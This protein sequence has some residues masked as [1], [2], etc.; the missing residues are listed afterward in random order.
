[1]VYVSNNRGTYSDLVQHKIPTLKATLFS[2][3]TFEAHV[4]A[5][6]AHVSRKALEAL[7]FSQT[8]DQDLRAML[9]ARFGIAFPPDTEQIDKEANVVYLKRRDDSTTEI[10]EA[11][12]KTIAPKGVQAA[13]TKVL[14]DCKWDPTSAD[15]GSLRVAAALHEQKF[16]R[17]SKT[18]DEA[19]QTPAELVKLYLECFAHVKKHPSD[20]DDFTTA[21]IL[22]RLGEAKQWE[23][24]TT[25]ADHFFGMCQSVDDND[26]NMALV[27]MLQIVKKSSKPPLVKIKTEPRDDVRPD[28]KVK[29]KEYQQVKTLAQRLKEA[30]EKYAAKHRDLECHTCGK[31]GHISPNCPL[32][33]VAEDRDS[34]DS[35][36][37]RQ[38][39]A[40]S[41][42]K[43]KEHFTKKKPEK[44]FRQGIRSS[45]R[46]ASAAT[47][48]EFS[49]EDV[50]RA[51]KDVKKPEKLRELV[52]L[53]YDDQKKAPA[54]ADE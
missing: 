10:I 13:T 31:K 44:V 5:Y 26:D 40:T 11:I 52:L 24:W 51:L 33:A 18:L 45:P 32:A 16:S 48:N 54:D 8:L 42:E 9:V 30:R 43:L 2:S 50:A 23:D 53:A 35:P 17:Y 22:E 28:K 38:R 20:S 41:S 36:P 27:G 7:W 14:D 37:H 15:I 6:E 4:R 21:K 34:S 39:D 49:R 29:D 12:R 47:K 46:F 1:M 3:V 19:Q 25:Y